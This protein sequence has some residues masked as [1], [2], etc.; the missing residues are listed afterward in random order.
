LSE[1]DVFVSAQDFEREMDGF[2]DLVLRRLDFLGQTELHILWREVLAER[3]GPAQSAARRMEARLGNQ[4]DE[5]PLSL[6]DRLVE[7]ATEAGP[8]VADEIAPACAGSQPADTL[9]EVM[10]L[11]SQPGVPGRINMPVNAGVDDLKSR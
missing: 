1:F 2:M 7:L 8:G 5:A 9:S 4:P 3:A 6:L 11:A 10:N